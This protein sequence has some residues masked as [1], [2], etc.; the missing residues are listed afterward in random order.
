M[1][2][3]YCSLWRS[4]L[5]ISYRQLGWGDGAVIRE[6]RERCGGIVL[7]KEPYFLPLIHRIRYGEVEVGINSV[8]RFEV[9]V[10]TSQNCRFH[11]WALWEP[12]VKEVVPQIEVG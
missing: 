1:S 4:L 5:V 7:Q 6:R 9:N 11:A 12:D 8:P 10:H 3:K 2:H